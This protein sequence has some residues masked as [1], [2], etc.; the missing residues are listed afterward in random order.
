[1]KLLKTALFFPLL[2]LPFGMPSLSAADADEIQLLVFSKT[3]GYRHDSIEAGIQALRR[4]GEAHRFAIEAS[5]DSAIFT[6]ER[7]AKFD[8]IVF[9]STTGTLFDADQREAFQG[10]I[11]GGGGFVGIHAAADTEYDWPWYGDLVGGYFRSHPHIQEAKIEVEDRKHPATRH[12]PEI[13]VH[14]DEWYD[15]I[16]NP[17]EKVRVLMSLDQD[18]YE[19]SLMGE[20]HPIAWYREFDGGRTF[21]TGVG[22]TKESYSDEAVLAHFAGA[23]EWAAGKKEAGETNGS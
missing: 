19:G 3:A 1:M 5:E 16:E 22:H 15:F 2:C 23:I 20:D 18:S 13:W 8:V 4:L 9:L 10:F 12:L 21:Y 11:R 14:T 17:R 7:L 6:P